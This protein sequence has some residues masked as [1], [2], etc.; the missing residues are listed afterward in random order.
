MLATIYPLPIT[1]PCW[2]L[3]LAFYYLHC[4]LAGISYLEYPSWLLLYSFANLYSCVYL[5]RNFELYV[6]KKAK[7]AYSI[8]NT[9]MN[10][11]YY[12][13]VQFFFLFSSWWRSCWRPFVK[14]NLE[15]IFLKPAF[16]IKIWQLHC[17]CIG[18]RKND[19]FCW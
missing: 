14:W 15:N 7:I 3:W 11:I 12:F 9:L 1:V 2:V 13:I 16:Y 18:G 10:I 5:N 4:V 17:M 19:L 8:E 6:S